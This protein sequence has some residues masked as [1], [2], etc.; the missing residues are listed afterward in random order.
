MGYRFYNAIPLKIRTEDCTVRTLSK[1]LNISWDSAFD[2][3]SKMAKSMGVMPSDKN[4]FSAVM[5][6]NGFYRENLPNF[7]QE[8]YS[9]KD[10]SEDNPNGRYVL[11]TDNHV[12]PVINGTYFDT[13]DSGDEYVMWFWTK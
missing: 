1:I 2:I 9:V 7:L 10:F 3:L 12:V 13:Y 4:V 5:R 11:C 6:M 8:D